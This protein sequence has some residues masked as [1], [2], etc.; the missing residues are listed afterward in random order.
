MTKIIR[1]IILCAVFVS[2]AAFSSVESVSALNNGFFLPANGAT[3]NTPAAACTQGALYQGFTGAIGHVTQVGSSNWSC[4]FDWPMGGWV[5]HSLGLIYMANPVCPTPSS[6]VAYTFN[7][8]TSL[9]ER[10]AVVNCPKSGTVIS[11][12]TYDYGA[13]PNAMQAGLVAGCTASCGTGG[14]FDP[15]SQR[16]LV[17]GV[18]HYYGTGVIY[19]T[20]VEC[21]AGTP[22]T[23]SSQSATITQTCAAGQV[24]VTSIAGKLNCYADNS[25]SSSPVATVAQ[26]S[27]S[28]VAAAGTQANAD[29]LAAINAAANA[30]GAAAAAAGGSAADIA[31]ARAA[32]G[33]A[34]AAAGAP[35]VAA[36]AADPLTEYCKNNP[37]ATICTAAAPST[38]AD[39]VGT[40]PLGD[41]YTGTLNPT[42]QKTFSDV[43]GTFKTSVL[44]SPVGAAA[45]GF[46]TVNVSGG[47]CPVW[48]TPPIPVIGTLTFDYYCQPPFQNLLPWMRAVMILIFSV[49]A[50]RIAV[51]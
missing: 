4:V 3:G 22:S 32:A 31:A 28:A 50:F 42:G 16:G 6:G 17:G 44:A 46:F 13:D 20:G 47:A 43:I 26:N 29:L 24:G 41:L 33:G 9:C 8:V 19:S 37:K 7:S 48:S 38:A 10:P 21:T 25:A 40:A 11:S 23:A 49:V 51:L 30:A 14:N 39:T 27:A 36:A 5:N 1:L 15:I 2:G 12:G 45:S 35:A 34:A 18:Y